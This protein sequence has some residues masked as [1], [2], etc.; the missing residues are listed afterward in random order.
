VDSLDNECI[1]LI[2]VHLIE[3]E[4]L[5]YYYNAADLLLLTSYHEGSPNVIKEA[6]ACN[7]PIVST[8]VGDVRW[9]IGD[10]KGCYLTSFDVVDVSEKIL[11]ALEYSAVNGSTNGRDRII[12][13]G[14]DS[15]SVAKKIINIYEQLIS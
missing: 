7:C 9:V 12:E 10:I 11:M 2:A 1:Q 15:A 8:D 4:L 13:L 5:K 14:L 3:H 6:M